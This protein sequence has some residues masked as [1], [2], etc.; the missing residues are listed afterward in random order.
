MNV[1]SLTIKDFKSIKNLSAEIKGCNVFLRGENGVGKSSFMKFIEI[2]FGKT[3]LVPP[4]TNIEGQV[5]A[6]KDGRIYTFDVKTDK[7]TGKAKVTV[8]LPEGTRDTSKSVIAGIVG[9]NEFDPERFVNLS[10]TD[11][12]RKKQVEEFKKFLDE[13]TQQFLAKYEASILVHFDERTEL[14]RDAKKLEGSINLNPMINHVHELDKFTETK[15]DAVMEDLKAAQKHNNQVN[16][17][18]TALEQLDQENTKAE[19]EIKELEKKIKSIQTGIDERNG[20]IKQGKIWLK[21]NV[22]KPTQALEDKIT[23]ATED[24]QKFNNAQG[25]KK[26]MEKLKILQDE[27]GEKTALIESQRQ[28][29]Q[30]AIRDM[31]GPIQDLLFNEEMLLYKGTPV[32]PESLSKSE[33]KK[34]GIRLKIAENPDLPLFIHEAESLGEDSLREIEELAKECGLQM[35]AEE[36][37]RGEKQLKV[38]IKTN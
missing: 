19:K 6:D 35:F 13:E 7:K 12:G 32:H 37:K 20:R 5:M 34:L 25:L 29:I 38:E 33:I 3:S 15:I 22:I 8:T 26:D 4:N 14:N 16:N 18:T 31:D 27:A 24:N 36:V 2:A 17:S 11:A 9:A 21:D 23:T 28:M 10:L 1:I 30:D